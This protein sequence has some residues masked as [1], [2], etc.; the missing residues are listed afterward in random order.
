ML[1]S[2]HAGIEWIV[3]I[4]I[5]FTVRGDLHQVLAA[6]EEV[7]SSGLLP[8]VPLPDVDSCA[9]PNVEHLTALGRSLAKLLGAHALECMHVVFGRWA[10]WTP[11]T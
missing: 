6:A 5:Q 1:V 8:A 10:I 9:V 4:K 11:F 2:Q 7:H 3:A